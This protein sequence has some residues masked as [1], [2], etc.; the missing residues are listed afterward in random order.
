[1]IRKLC[2]LILAAAV[3][4]F[5]GAPMAP[6]TRVAAAEEPVESPSQPQSDAAPAAKTADENPYPGTRKRRGKNGQTLYCWSEKLTGTRISRPVCATE[7]YMKERAANATQQVDDM[8]EAATRSGC[9]PG[10]GVSE[11]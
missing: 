10:S 3:A 7:A 9:I 2:C 6:A 1:M 8:R 5:T 4:S 11:C